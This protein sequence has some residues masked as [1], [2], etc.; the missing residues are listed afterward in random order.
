[1][2]TLRRT[3]DPSFNLKYLLLFGAAVIGLN[4]AILTGLAAAEVPILVLMGIVFLTVA[5]FS[6]KN[7]DIATLCFIVILFTNTA[8]IMVKFHGVPYIATALPPLMLL[9]P[10]AY[11]VLL[12]RQKIVFTPVIFLIIGYLLVQILGTFYSKDI[13]LAF[14]ALYS[15]FLEGFTIYF[16]LVNTIRTQKVLN[17]AILA[18]LFSALVL[19]AIPGFQQVTRT[20]DN[21][22]L[23]YGQAVGR[24]FSTS[25]TLISE[26][27]QPRLSGAIGEKNRFAQIMLMLAMVCLSQI[28]SQNPMAWRAFAF[29]ATAAAAV[30]TVL[31]FS[32]GAAVGFG[33]VLIVGVM[34]RLISPWR[35]VIIVVMSVFMLVAFPQYS[36]RLVSIQDIAAESTGD[37]Q[38]QA[39]GATVGRL[40]VMRAAIILYAEHPVIGVGPG[41]YK[42]YS[43][44]IGNELGTKRLD[45]NRQAH[46]LY[47]DIAAN[48]GTLGFL[49]VMGAIGL[50][51][52]QLLQIRKRWRDENPQ[53]A[54][55]ATGLALG[56]IAYL[57][58]GVFLHFAY[59]RYFWAFMGLI[60]AT[61]EVARTLEKQALSNPD[62][63]TAERIAQL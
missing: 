23:G 58:T 31:P 10:F 54:S 18:V 39:D 35:L 25:E 43:K 59:I 34:L 8:T 13:K 30:G 60:G 7:P 26:E 24:G 41:M 3:A 52:R 53:L 1:M 44:D 55:I 11:Y 29:A 33:L 50:S 42:Y 46:N 22:Y 49:A 56:L 17:R 14:T 6:L 48:S 2:A 19:G 45:E 47:L 38:T 12:R 36:E 37:S 20:F 63:A 28:G 5:L 4:A 9:L 62:R 57:A 32:R 15:F 40:T 16:L 27:T 21:N 61:V 51:L